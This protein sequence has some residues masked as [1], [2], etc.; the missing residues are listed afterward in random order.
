MKAVVKWI[1]NMS[2]VGESESGHS[3]VMDGSPEAAGET[4]ASGQWKWC[5]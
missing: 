3:V 5:C 4:L 2:F 1:D